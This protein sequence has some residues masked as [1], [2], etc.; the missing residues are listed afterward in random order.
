MSRLIVAYLLCFGLSICNAQNWSN[1]LID[2]DV[3]NR[4]TLQMADY[5]LGQPFVESVFKGLE[6]LAFI[7][8]L[9]TALEEVVRSANTAKLE[10]NENTAIKAFY[11]NRVEPLPVVS[12]N[13]HSPS[14]KDVV[15]P[16]QVATSVNAY[17]A[18]KSNLVP[19]DNTIAVNKAGQLIIAN[20]NKIVL[21]DTNGIPYFQT[22]N[23]FFTTILQESCDPKVF[24]DRKADRF[25]VYGQEN[26]EQN[27][28]DHPKI[29]LAVMSST[30]PLEA[31]Q[32]YTIEGEEGVLFDYPKVAI[33]NTE[34]IVT[35]SLHRKSS[36][37]EDLKGA[38]IYQFNKYDLYSNRAVRFRV[39]E[40]LPNQTSF[41]MPVHSNESADTTFEKVYLLST[42]WQEESQ[43]LY[44]Y[45]I[46]HAA[47]AQNARMSLYQVR[48]DQR[49]THF[50]LADQLVG[51]RINNLDLRMMDG[52]K[53]GNDIVYV[54]AN[55]NENHY[56][57]IDLNLLKLGGENLINKS[58]LLGAEKQ[59][60]Y[61]FPSVNWMRTKE[62]E[63]KIVVQ[64]CGS[65]SDQYPKVYFN[66]CDEALNCEQEQV[67]YFSK[68]YI[69]NQT[70]VNRWGDYT[71]IAANQN[72][73]ALYLVASGIE[74]DEHKFSTVL[75][76]LYQSDS[77]SEPALADFSIQYMI[78]TS[79]L[80]VGG[81]VDSILLIDTSGI[82]YP[83]STDKFN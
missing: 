8:A 2:K 5:E 6:S 18:R 4:S 44:L 79:A 3:A 11:D 71:T 39:W 63:R 73:T 43:D 35:G 15:N 23:G 21:I 28:I 83:L 10:L 27:Y 47:V 37:G 50:R 82:H 14:Y 17:H 62:N 48:R 20:N 46:D 65:A 69:D 32:Y 38:R 49:I 55:G 64:Y 16:F 61:M 67:L 9:D 26:S 12:Q 72:H 68:S 22:L 52:Y 42:N 60:S 80:T 53:L 45:Q 57:K 36:E 70:E 56:S 59:T 25:M 13:L 1:Q 54:F 77:L 78:N 66:Y 33:T 81:A 24:Y 30:D 74:Q 29:A 40:N 41:I 7:I 58:I 19:E 51:N 34:V 31:W 75:T 76:Q